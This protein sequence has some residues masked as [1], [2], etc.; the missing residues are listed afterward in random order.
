[1][2]EKVPKWWSRRR[3]WMTI[4]KGKGHEVE[5]R[6]PGFWSGLQS[7]PRCEPVSCVLTQ[8]LRTQNPL[9][10]NDPDTQTR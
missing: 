1:M 10:M 7:S 2:A 5:A 3:D 4:T 9:L 6:S 8:A